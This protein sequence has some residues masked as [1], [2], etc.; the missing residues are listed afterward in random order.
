M[1]PSL[2]PYTIALADIRNSARPLSNYLLQLSVVTRLLYKVEDLLRQSLIGNTIRHVSFMHTKLGSGSSYGQAAPCPSVMLEFR[3]QV[4]CWKV[5]RQ[6]RIK[7]DRGF[8]PRV[9][10][11][12]SPLCALIDHSHISVRR[13]ILGAI[14]KCQVLAPTREAASGAA[15]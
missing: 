15:T 6:T 7:D 4:D 5:G 1:I 12:S 11:V 3:D 9:P 8:K 10:C 2:A 14:S 13:N